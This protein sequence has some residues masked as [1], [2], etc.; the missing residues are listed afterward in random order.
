[1]FELP[2]RNS[3][4]S[5]FHSESDPNSI[6][7]IKQLLEKNQYHIEFCISEQDLIKNNL[8]DLLSEPG[9]NSRILWK[10]CSFLQEYIQTIEDQLKID[11]TRSGR[12]F[13]A[14]DIACGSGRDCLFLSRRGCWNVV[15]IDNDQILLNKMSKAIEMYCNPPPESTTNWYC[16]NILIDLEEGTP[17]TALD[18][19]QSPP[20]TSEFILSLE[21]KLKS[22]SSDGEGFDLVHVARYLY[23]PIFQT[24]K[25]L[26]RKGGFIVYHTFMLPVHSKPRRPRF[27]LNYN[28]LKNRFSDQFEIIQYKETLLDDGRPIQF[29]LAKK[30]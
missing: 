8:S 29:L 6:E 28:E 27:L 5:I 25:N 12:L 30:K 18:D 14:I 24:L 26:V 10:S 11:I 7:S 2:P 13:E 4:I 1:M 19:S 20:D 3:T 16:K 23:R 22:L 17:S 21:K 9:R 15:G